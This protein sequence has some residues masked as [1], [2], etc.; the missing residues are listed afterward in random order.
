MNFI[1]L[2]ILHSL[3]TLWLSNGAPKKLAQPMKSVKT[4]REEN[5]TDERAM[6][7]ANPCT[8]IIG[9]ST[10]KLEIQQWA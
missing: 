3:E 5:D 2:N 10:F 1:R 8:L 9:K 4:S 6:P 7:A